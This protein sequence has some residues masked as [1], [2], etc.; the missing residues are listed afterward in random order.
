[1]ILRW[2]LVVLLTVLLA[3]HAWPTP[4]TRH[5][6]SAK[7]IEE[8]HP[9]LRT[10]SS[11][12]AFLP[13]DEF[14]VDT[15]T[16]AYIPRY[17]DQFQPSVAFD[18]TNYLVVWLD[19]YYSIR[20]TR[21]RQDG[22]LLDPSGIYL[23]YGSEN[24]YPQ[25]VF[26][27]TDFFVVWSDPP[28][29]AGSRITP[30]GQVRD[31]FR[32]SVTRRADL[33]ARCSIAWAG[34]EGLVVWT[35]SGTNHQ[36]DIRA[37]RVT[38]SGAVRDSQGLPISTAPGNQ[39]SPS[40]AFDGN[41]YLVVW[42]DYRN[43]TASYIYAA[44]VDT[45]GAVVDTS[46]FPVSPGPR[47]QLNPAL[48]F[49]DSTYL[50]AWEDA[51]IDPSRDIYC[52]RVTPDARVL[53]STGVVVSNAASFQV[54]PRVAFDG[55][56]FML[57]WVDWRSGVADIYGAR[58]TQAGVVLDTAGIPVCLAQDYQGDP[59]IG[60][61]DSNYLAVWHDY[62][63]GDNSE[64]F[65]ARID[66]AGRV[67]DTTGFMISTYGTWDQDAPSAAFLGSSYVVAWQQS[68]EPDRICFSRLA[69]DGSPLDSAPHA[70]CPSTDE[71]LTSAIAAGESCALVVWLDGSSGGVAGARVSP[72][73]AGLDSAEIVIMNHEEWPE[74]VSVAGC[75]DD[76]LVVWDEYGN[77]GDIRGV[78]VSLA[79]E[80][81]D[82]AGI[83][84][85]GAAEYQ[86][87]ARVAAGDSGYLVV[88]IDEASDPPRVFAGRVTRSGAVLDSAGILVTLDS[89]Q[90][91]A[92]QVAFGGNGYLVVWEDRL[93][94]FDPHEICGARLDTH[95]A[96]MDSQPILIAGVGNNCR[97]PSVTFD[98]DD[99]IVA[100]RDAD[101]GSINGARVSRWG[102]VLATFPVSQQERDHRRVC[103]VQGAGR[104]VLALYSAFTDWVNQRPVSCYRIWG[105]LP[106][107]GAIEE[108]STLAAPRMTLDVIPNPLSGM[109]EVHYALP[110][111]SR[112]R[113]GVY[114]ATGR[115]VCRLTDRKQKAGC[116]SVR[117]NGTDA[118]GRALA[119]GVYILRLD[120]GQRR[121][122]R[123]VVIAK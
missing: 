117:W 10:P 19:E 7:T 57:D 94:P 33:D 29:I 14:L 114:D 75:G 72:S 21:V 76:W 98:G 25:A 4:S 103:L 64:I 108:N 9:A 91:Y 107:F 52:A 20:A 122:T 121:E 112:V 41:R 119:N 48:A 66:G 88:W 79:G 102:T 15:T 8:R 93:R 40:V 16:S 90:R 45:C 62:R 6:R 74:L 18:G 39:E 37:T 85:C 100:W 3:V 59:G 70:L 87:D 42:H 28:F 26:D 53:D 13:G 17:G 23:S 89:S 86:Y 71:Q 106:P 83:L 67:L 58:V 109:G 115:Q 118:S 44:R 110:V 99:Y 105:R 116:Y 120:L 30:E 73:G 46:G 123:T 43:G 68:G 55:V 47:R 95:G 12:R 24:S 77:D 82:T 80:V 32:I 92:P 1:M 111:E 5:Q 51:R 31:T 104:D 60:F 56:S 54:L 34:S 38:R 96:V 49:G 50:V 11:S 63:C 69:L 101:S 61:G 22:M 84:I 2:R 78:R 97:S 36:S 27:G 81:L 65:G 113:L 35:D